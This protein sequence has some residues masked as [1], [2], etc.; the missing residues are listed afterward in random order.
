MRI[1]GALVDLVGLA[2]ETDRAS[3][4]DV[5]VL[6][7]R[8]TQAGY[9]IREEPNLEGLIAQRAR[10]AGCVQSLAGRLGSFEAALVSSHA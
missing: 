4:A 1:A 10:H 8:L 5:T 9:P 6:L 3:H 2:H 7:E